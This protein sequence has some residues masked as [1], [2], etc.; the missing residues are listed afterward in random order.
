VSVASVFPVK[1]FINATFGGI[2][3]SIMAVWGM[4]ALVVAVRRFRW[5]PRSG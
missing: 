3:L 2:D 4:A 1:H 5:L